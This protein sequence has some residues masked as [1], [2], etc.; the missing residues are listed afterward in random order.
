MSDAAWRWVA[1]DVTLAIHDEQLAEHGGL[2]GVRDLA[3]IQSA[4]AKP[5]NLIA[6]GTPDV[7]DLAASYAYGLA[8]NHGFLDGNKR[9]AYVVALLF[10][11]ANGY[12]CVASDTDSVTTMLD[13]ASGAMD[14]Q[15][16]AAWFRETIEP[17]EAA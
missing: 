12:E 16:L 8:R 5:R 6:Y 17:I 11:L 2:V 14:E 15:R 13:V 4:L 10:L 1:E 3:L 9:T 7:A